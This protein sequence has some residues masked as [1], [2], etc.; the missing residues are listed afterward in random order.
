MQI[1]ATSKR[2]Y[3]S[4][5]KLTFPTSGTTGMN[6]Q[7]QLLSKCGWDCHTAFVTGYFIGIEKSEL[8]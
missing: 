2:P 4:K 7:V 6:S 1:S 3:F 8:F 5:I